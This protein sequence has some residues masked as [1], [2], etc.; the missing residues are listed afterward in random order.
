MLVSSAP[1][2]AG[3]NLFIFLSSVPTHPMSLFITHTLDV[4]VCAFGREKEEVIVYAC[5]CVGVGGCFQTPC[6]RA[7]QSF[8]TWGRVNELPRKDPVLRF[9]IFGFY[10]PDLTIKHDYLVRA[11]LL[12]QF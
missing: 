6:I 8:D 10:S 5:M 2:L 11:P 4:L 12:V 1:Y 9:N 3:L 7:K